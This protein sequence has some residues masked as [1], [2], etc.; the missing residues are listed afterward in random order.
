MKNLLLSV[1]VLGALVLSA[2]NQESS[3][4]APAPKAPASQLMTAADQL[5]LTNDQLAD[6]TVAWYSGDDLT[7]L[8][9]SRQIVLVDMMAR[10]SGEASVFDGERGGGGPGN[11]FP[12]GALDMNAMTMYRLILQANPDLTEEQKAALKTAM[13]EYN[14]LR[15]EIMMNKELTPEQKKAALDAAFEALKLKI[16]GDPTNDQT[17]GILTPE[18]V[19]AYEALKAKIEEERQ[20]RIDKM[21]QLRIDR[22]V[23]M[24]TRALKLDDAQKAEFKNLITAR[25]QEI[26]AARQ[27]YKNDPEGLRTALKEIMTRYD[28]QLRAVLNGDQQTIWDKMHSGRVGR[29]G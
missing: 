12:G 29:G 6:L 15:R 5:T 10:A 2:C 9:N 23:N 11:R 21:K 27:T 28:A 22:E 3:V 19:K 4:N 24:W 16:F 26:E 13:E 7:S 17:P 20:S 1:L 25:E 18:Q 14:T 8:L